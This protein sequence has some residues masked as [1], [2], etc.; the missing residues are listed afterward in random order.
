[1]A[2][3][4]PLFF[5]LAFSATSLAAQVASKQTAL[6]YQVTLLGTFAGD[7]GYATAINDLN[8]VAGYGLIN[9]F[10]GDDVRP[11]LYKNGKL[12]QLPLASNAT[13]GSAKGINHYDQVVG[14][15]DNGGNLT[16]AFVYRNNKITDLGTLT[17]SPGETSQAF[18][19]NDSGDVVGLDSPSSG[20]EQAFLYRNGKMTGIA[21]STTPNFTFLEA[22]AINNYGQIVGVCRFFPPILPSGIGNDHAALFQNGSI[23]DLGTL[24][25]SATSLARAINS[26]GQVVG[27][28]FFITSPPASGVN[29][30]FLY[31]NGVMND[32]GN[33]AATGIND[34]GEVVGGGDDGTPEG[35]AFL[36]TTTRGLA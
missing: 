33:G 17:N 31:K 12:L 6:Q 36:Y 20:G 14:T 8:H 32:I 35:F 15:F 11:F 16:H 30:A 21:E 1:M 19:I 28:S 25:G 2:T 13:E 9:G 18:G 22:W 27:S 3:G 5:L 24:P 29:H 10:T 34:N 7:Q 26:S 4:L 23:V